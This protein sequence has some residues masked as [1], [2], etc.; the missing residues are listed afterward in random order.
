LLA[1][2][3]DGVT[4]AV[5]EWGQSFQEQR[6]LEVLSGAS[7]LPAATVLERVLAAVERFV[8]VSELRDD[9]A[10]LVIRRESHG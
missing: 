10:V 3:S 9:L 2:F 4:D 5:N 1:L 7:S 8:G 6:F